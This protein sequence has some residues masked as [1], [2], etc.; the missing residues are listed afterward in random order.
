MRWQ[1][2]C[3]VSPVPPEPEAEHLRVLGFFF[4]KA[5]R[6]QR[7]LAVFKTMLVP[8]SKLGESTVRQ[9]VKARQSCSSG[10]SPDSLVF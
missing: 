5:V 6:R 3:H 1:L 4:G 7:I 2:E 9:P 10:D 8:H